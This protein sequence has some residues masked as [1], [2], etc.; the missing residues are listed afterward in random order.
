MTEKIGYNKAIVR[1]R[2]QQ[3]KDIQAFKLEAEKKA[4]QK[5]TAHCENDHKSGEKPEKATEKKPVKLLKKGNVV[6]LPKNLSKAQKRRIKK[7]NK[8]KSA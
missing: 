7:Q 3:Y 2:N 6:L 8:K 5:K 4:E 1:Y